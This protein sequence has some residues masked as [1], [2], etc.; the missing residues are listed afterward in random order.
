[1]KQAPKRCITSK[2]VTAMTFAHDTRGANAVLALEIS[3]AV[4][5]FFQRIDDYRLYRQTLRT[6]RDLDDRTLVDLGL[7]RSGLRA[8]ALRA[9]YGFVR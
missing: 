6:L 9:T 7:H 8:E 4:N 5:H 2:D 3:S 1:M